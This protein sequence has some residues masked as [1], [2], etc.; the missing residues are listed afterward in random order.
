LVGQRNFSRDGVCFVIT[1]NRLSDSSAFRAEAWLG[2][3]GRRLLLAALSVLLA[4]QSVSTPG[5]DAPAKPAADAPVA[6]PPA[7]VA[8]VAGQFVT[9]GSPVDDA[10]YGRVS[11]AALS[12]Q[13]IARKEKRKAVLVLEVKPGTSQFHHVQGLAKFL[14]T[15]VPDVLT[16]AWIPETVR[17]NQAVVALACRE[18]VMA[19]SA[20]FGDLGLGK[21]LDPDEQAFVYRLANL[22]HNVRLSEALL[23]GMCD[24]QAEVIWAQVETGGGAQPVL[25]SRLVTPT[26]F[27][28]LLQAKAV[29]PR[30]ETIKQAGTAGLFSGEKARSF[31]FLI[32]Q[33]ADSRDEVGQLYQLPRE[34]QREKHAADDIKPIVINVHDMIEPILEQFVL[35]QIDRAISSGK[36]LIIFHVESPG[37]YLDASMTL[38]TRISELQEQGIRTV[39]YIPKEAISGAAIISLGAD[40]IYLHPTGK[41]GDAAPIEVRPGGWAERAPEKIL[42]ILTGFQR[43][44]AQKKN[45]PPALCEAMADRKLEVFQ[46]TH[47]DTGEVAY[48]TDN[49]IHEAAGLWVKGRMIP[50]SGRELLLTVNGVRAHELKLAETPVENFDELKQRLGLS[51]DIAVPTAARSW[52]DDL[53]FLLNT[54]AITALLFVLGIVCIYLELHMPIGLF[55]IGSAIC[56]ALFF[57][58]RFLGGTA[59][60]L[61]VVL[62][63]LGASLVAIEVFLLPGFLVFGLSGVLLMLFALIMA[64]Q[65]FVVPLTPGDYESLGKT[66]LSLLG[67]LAGAILLM[68]ILGRFLPAIPLFEGLVLHPPG[69]EEGTLA[70]PRLDPR[71]VTAASPT[72]DSSVPVVVGQA[73]TTTTLL[74]PAGKAMFGT[75]LVDVL[76]DGE[77]ISAGTRVE[78]VEIDSLRVIVRAIETA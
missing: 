66:S 40:E 62:F 15:E 63:L 57:W 2:R 3:V 37:G 67:S 46:A 53:V 1:A 34:A 29:V 45:R 78:V 50:E 5:Q 13:T 12:L 71:L 54:S 28:R 22:R 43:E 27:E 32:S 61:E 70:A 30:H 44:M 52:A 77:M 49:E 4:L 18:I 73:G 33:T 72:V 69:A 26:E 25:E 10:V 39:A 51:A 65:T 6:A 17:G 58:S 20:E 11:R 75:E 16:V 23:R 59:G 31:G 56:F 19:P 24:P 76:S 68:G 14:T 38:A 8:A 74:R 42:S 35:R 48:M 21:A 36:N 64:T 9:V 60:W 7:A 47:R 55:G 41:I